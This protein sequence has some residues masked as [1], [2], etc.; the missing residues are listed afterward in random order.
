MKAGADTSVK[1]RKEMTT[2]LLARNYDVIR[3]L[4]QEN[5]DVERLSKEDRSHILWHACNEGEL[6]MVQCVIKAG[7]DVDHFHE[8]QTPVMMA[9][10][11][12]HDRIVKELIL[13]NCDVNLKGDVVF[14]DLALS[15]NFARLIQS[16]YT[17]S[18]T[19]LV[20]ILP[21]IQFQMEA[22]AALLTD[23]ICGVFW[24]YS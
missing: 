19:M 15:L 8:G 9:T 20:Y 3:Q 18:M 5:G 12:G 16:K 14:R 23:L 10:L 6:N 4:I 22:V 13:A 24:F 2:V 21:W 7:C 11:R 1:D 17:F